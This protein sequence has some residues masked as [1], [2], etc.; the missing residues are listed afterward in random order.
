MTSL[1]TDALD[2]CL[3]TF[4]DEAPETPGV[5]ALVVAAG[6]SEWTG[7]AGT[8]DRAGLEPMQPNATFRLASNTKTFTAA[9]ILRLAEQ[10]HLRLDD[11]VEHYIPPDLVPRLNVIDGVSYGETITLLHLLHHT[12]GL[13]ATTNEGFMDYV[14]AHPRKRW[15]PLEKV[16]W[17]AAEGPAAFPPGDRYEYNDSGYVLLAI[18]IEQAAG[19]LLAEAFRSLLRFDELGL[20]AVH[21]ETLEEVPP[22]AGPRMP[23]YLHDLD[24]GGIDPSF[25][26]WGGGGLVSDIADLAGFW[27][28]L[29]A[30]RVFDSPETLARMCSTI[31]SGLSEGW[32][33]V[34]L[35]VFSQVVGRRVWTHTG[36]WGTGALHEPESN[37][38]IAVAV[39]QATTPGAA[40]LNLQRRLVVAAAP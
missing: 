24:V 3:S 26:L 34:G 35:G 33:R 30:G 11:P 7:A 20:H 13:H 36:F 29:F 25:D 21:L 15:T 12:S 14:R 37:L 4:L 1:D 5:L 18:V 31:P 22:S 38:T 8:A 16:E 27:R 40:F 28:A 32:D 23:Q 2:R 17:V 6:S 9:A 19:T 10:G 39:N